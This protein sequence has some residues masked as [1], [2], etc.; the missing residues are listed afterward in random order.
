MELFSVCVWSRDSLW[1]VFVCVSDLLSLYPTCPSSLYS[2]LVT[3]GLVTYRL[4]VLYAN[5]LLFLSANGRN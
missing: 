5:P 2:G 1:M 3:Q 4:H